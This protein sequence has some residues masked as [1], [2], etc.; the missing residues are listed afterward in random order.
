MEEHTGTRFGGF[1]VFAYDASTSR[2]VSSEGSMPGWKRGQHCCSGGAS[3]SVEPAAR[4]TDAQTTGQ[5]TRDAIV[6][7]QLRSG[8]RLDK[9]GV[10]RKRRRRETRDQS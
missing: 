6:E 3:S 2:T 5:L 4:N 9:C 7:H 1:G 10:G 8:E